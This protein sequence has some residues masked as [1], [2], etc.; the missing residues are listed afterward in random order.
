MVRWRIPKENSA[1]HFELW[2]ELWVDYPKSHREKFRFTRSRFFTFT[3]E[4]SSEESW[5][6]LD[7]YEDQ[8]VYDKQMKALHEDPELV[9]LLDELFSKL[10]VLIVPGSMKGQVWTEVEKLRVDFKQLC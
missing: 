6:F 2:S 10:D 9:R 4:G 7:E 5:M 3:E 8:E 1:K